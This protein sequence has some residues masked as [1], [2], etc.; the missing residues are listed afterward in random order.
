MIHIYQGRQ[1]PASIR[2]QFMKPRVSID[3]CRKFCTPKDP[4]PLSFIRWL[5]TARKFNQVALQ[6]VAPHLPSTKRTGRMNLWRKG[7]NSEHRNRMWDTTVMF[8]SRRYR[9]QAASGPLLYRAD[10]QPNEM[11]AG[12]LESVLLSHTIGYVFKL[13]PSWELSR[14]RQSL[15]MPTP[16][17]RLAV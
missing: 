3:V 9:N 6:H 2:I 12:H 8:Q 10:P 1:N 5:C 13:L 14:Y 16:L 17:F 11:S 4:N 15:S 7:A